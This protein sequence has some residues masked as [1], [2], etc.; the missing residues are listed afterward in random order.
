MS[1]ASPPQLD[2]ASL[3]DALARVAAGAG[4]RDRATVPPFPEE[5]IA[6]LEAV[7]ALAWNAQPGADRPP[8]AA[9]LGLVR[10]VARAD[11]SVGR[12]LDGHLN[13]VE[14][15]AVQA[16]EPLRD[17]EL[18]AV[19]AGRLRV[20]V[21]GGDPHPDEGTPATVATVGDGEVL[22]GV[23]TFCSGAGGLDRALIL[24]RD[25]DAPAPVAVWVDL[26]DPATVAI[27][28]GWYRGAGMRASVSH[29]VIFERAP[30]LA[31]FG[32]PGALGQQPWFGRDALRTAAS[33]AGMADGAVDGA[34]EVI[35]GR[36]DCGALEQ[37]ATGRMLT[38]QETISAWLE[39]AARAM[40][41]A[42]ED[43]AEVALHARAAITQAAHTIVAEAERACGSHPF[44]TGGRLDRARRDL[45]LF[46]LQHRLDP[47]L[48][49]AGARALAARRSV[50]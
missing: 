37:L 44:A 31:R 4:E 22:S 17:H 24:A 7:G 9:E 2:V 21:W 33:W 35:A 12:I 38:A 1:T 3:D 23:K 45:E 25:P 42:S 28:D 8:A 19:R 46:L 10:S 5:A 47:A 27:D 26:T 18:A 11:G 41:I 6:D 50:R 48:A 15:L 39:R 14:R 43:L 29:R 30:V 20:G 13:G 49:A 16:P 36:P 34:L 40:D 32:G